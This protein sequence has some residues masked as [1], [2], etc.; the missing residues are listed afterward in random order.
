MWKLISEKSI[1]K[2]VYLY[3]LANIEDCFLK[4]RTILKIIWQKDI[5]SVDYIIIELI[6][7]NICF[8]SLQTITLQNSKV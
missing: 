6:K 3:F 7:S 4:K 2:F 1:I 5:K 8:T